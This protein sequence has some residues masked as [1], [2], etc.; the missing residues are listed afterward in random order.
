M[1]P[2]AIIPSVAKTATVEVAAR[3]RCAAS[4]LAC[5][6]FVTIP[7]VA[8]WFVREKPGWVV[9]WVVATAEF[10]ALKILTLS[11]LWR[12]APKLRVAAYLSLWPGMD[13]ATFLGS[14]VTRKRLPPTAAEWMFAAAKLVG[15]LVMIGWTLAHAQN[16]SSLMLGWAGMLGIIFTL[17]FGAFHLASLAWRR[18]GINAAPLMRAPIAARSLGE[19]WSV[20]WNAAFADAARRFIGR[21]LVKRWGAGA[22]SALIFLISGLVHESVISVPARGGWGGPTLYFVIQAFGVWF[23]KTTPGRRMGLGRGI[24]GWIWVLVI[25]VGPVP[26]LFHPPFVTEVIAPFFKTLAANFP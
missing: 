11:G 7:A 2:L 3:H 12:A 8:W 6:G 20:R 14:G 22:T 19:F 16:T 21:P 15:G 10:A 26:L 4:C 18:V 13:A 9:M 23:E 5:V 1:K 25:T 17:H 24:R